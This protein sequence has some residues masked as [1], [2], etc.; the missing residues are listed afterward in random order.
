MLV[1]KGTTLQ[2]TPEYIGYRET[3]QTHTLVSVRREKSK[4][5]EDTKAVRILWRNGWF[6]W[7]RDN[8]L[9]FFLYVVTLSWNSFL[10][11]GRGVVGTTKL[12]C[13]GA[14]IKALA[15]Y[16]SLLHDQKC[17]KLKSCAYSSNN[18]FNQK[19]MFPVSLCMLCHPF[20]AKQ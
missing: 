20:L 5:K 18:L 10:F 8:A 7:R 15:R 13:R 9:F 19:I 1:L 17:T 14:G 16:Y 3:N 4:I 12:T 6:H 11:H 2:L